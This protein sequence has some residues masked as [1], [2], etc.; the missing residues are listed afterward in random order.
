MIDT[1]LV[2]LGSSNTWVG[3]GKA[4]VKTSTSVETSNK[5]VGSFVRSHE[6]PI[7]N[8]L[9]DTVRGLWIW[10]LQWYGVHRYCDPDQWSC[11]TGP[12]DWSCRRIG[13][14]FRIGWHLGVRENH[15]T[16]VT[17]A[18]SLFSLGPTDLTLGTLSPA[19]SA[20]IPTVLDNGFNKGLLNAYGVAISFEPTTSE[21]DINGELSFGGVDTSK[22][23]GNI[24]FAPISE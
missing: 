6:T 19:T 12:I 18:D 2:D 15:T 14:L 22:F 8:K 7:S 21:S 10:F 4:Y 13:R 11:H 3:A 17:A 23:I 9:S 5:V 20:T 1:L 16:S 24:T